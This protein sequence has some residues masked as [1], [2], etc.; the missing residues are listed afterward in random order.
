[1]DKF[2]VSI[3]TMFLFVA[4]ID[5]IENDCN[6]TMIVLPPTDMYATERLT[7]MFFFS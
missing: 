1:M 5:F 4:F 7:V 3:T 2:C 6:I